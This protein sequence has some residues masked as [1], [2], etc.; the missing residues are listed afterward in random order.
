MHDKSYSS[1]YNK[2]KREREKDISDDKANYYDEMLPGNP[3]NVRISML[4]KRKQNNVAVFKDL[5]KHQ[6]MEEREI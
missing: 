4:L 5:L 1:K 3:A 6:T 2:K